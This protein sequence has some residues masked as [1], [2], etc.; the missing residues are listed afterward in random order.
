MQKIDDILENA[1]IYRETSEAAGDLVLFNNRDDAQK[2]LA[3]FKEEGIKET[4]IGQIAYKGE[5]VFSDGAWK[6]PKIAISE[7]ILLESETTIGYYSSSSDIDAWVGDDL[8]SALS[9]YVEPH[10]KRVAEALDLAGGF[11]VNYIDGDEYNGSS[12]ANNDSTSDF[13]YILESNIKKIDHTFDDHAHETREIYEIF[14][15]FYKGKWLRVTYSQW[16][17]SA[18]YYC[19]LLDTNPLEEEE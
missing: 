13:D 18:D 11:F 4:V 2:A 10:P 16:Q 3:L 8:E 17:G 7:V 12:F 14:D 1:G 5:I 19:E 6:G 15:G 9:C